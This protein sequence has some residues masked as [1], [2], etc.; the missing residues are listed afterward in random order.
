MTA[1][2]G[3]VD[4][5]SSLQSI[6]LNELRSFQAQLEP[7]C[8]LWSGDAFLGKKAATMSCPGPSPTVGTIGDTLGGA[9]SGSSST[10]TAGTIAGP[11]AVPAI[12]S[13][14]QISGHIS[15]GWEGKGAALG[16]G[17]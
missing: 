4:P 10:S 6:D 17:M 3:S 8:I 1:R 13:V 12:W 14:G 15:S 16:K 5:R 9:A 7:M 11:M 2:L